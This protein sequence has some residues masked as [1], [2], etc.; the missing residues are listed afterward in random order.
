MSGHPKPPKLARLTLAPRNSDD[1][2]QSPGGM[3]I[4]ALSQEVQALRAEK[5]PM[6]DLLDR[7]LEVVESAYSCPEWLQ[8]GRTERTDQTLVMLLE[9]LGPQAK[10]AQ[11]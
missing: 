5:D 1:S 4:G 6:T 10:R 8:Y 9:A 11:L 7:A 2:T 3:I